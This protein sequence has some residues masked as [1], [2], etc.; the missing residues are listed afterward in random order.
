MLRAP[1]APACGVWCLVFR[2]WCLVLGAWCLVFG[3]WCLV[4]GVWCLMFGGWGL[5]FRDG[6]LRFGIWGGVYGFR[7]WV[8][9][10]GLQGKVSGSRVDGVG[11]WGAIHLLRAVQGSEFRSYLRVQVYLVIYDSG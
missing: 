8:S 2:A 11:I 5:G 7:V 4:F 6:G 9:G 10:W 3:V 1:N